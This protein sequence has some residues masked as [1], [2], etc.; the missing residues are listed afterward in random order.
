MN[1]LHPSILRKD[2][3]CFQ[4]SQDCISFALMILY[5]PST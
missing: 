3:E 4:S 2:V 1:F 5:N